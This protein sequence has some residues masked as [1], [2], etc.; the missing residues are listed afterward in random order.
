MEFGKVIKTFTSKKG[1]QVVFRYPKPDD[2]ATVWNYANQLIAEDTFIELSGKPIKRKEEE[3]WFKNV[4]KQ[5]T[6]KE[7]IYVYVE[8]DRVFAGSAHL[9]LGTR[10]RKHTGQLGI[11]L[12]APFRDEGIGTELLRYLIN[13]AKK[14]GLKLLLLSCFENNPRA[15]HVYEKLG[16]QKAGIIPQAIE[17]K[18]KYCGEVKLYLQLQ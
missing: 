2:F 11:S 10:R 14:L 16:F 13:Q 7:A 3:K 18:G 8:V 1:N 9:M 5:M 15:L 4:L 6:K 12:A 17:Y